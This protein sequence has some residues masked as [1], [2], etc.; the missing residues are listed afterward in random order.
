MKGDS[1]S[2]A[3]GNEYSFDASTS[4]PAITAKYGKVG[5]AMYAVRIFVVPPK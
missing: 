1:I 5:A 2:V 3:N 4:D